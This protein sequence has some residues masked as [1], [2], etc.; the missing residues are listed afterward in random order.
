MARL[1]VAVEA[2]PFKPV[3]GEVDAVAIVG[4]GLAIDQDLRVEPASPSPMQI[5]TA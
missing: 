1:R 4:V 5:P 2:A 3:T